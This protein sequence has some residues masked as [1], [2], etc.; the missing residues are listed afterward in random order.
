MFC[1]DLILNSQ[2]KLMLNAEQENCQCKFLSYLQHNKLIS[3]QGKEVIL[4]CMIKLII[5][6]LIY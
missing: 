6:E 1:L 3:R 2:F 4:P 5:V